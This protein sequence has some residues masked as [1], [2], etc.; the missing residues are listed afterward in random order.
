[1]RALFIAVIL[2]VGLP[3]FS[4]SQEVVVRPG[5]LLQ[6]AIDAAPAG[7]VIVLSEGRWEEN[8]KIEKSLTLRGTGADVTVISGVE[9]GCPVVWIAG[10]DG[11]EPISV[12]IE[13]L[14]ITGAAGE[15]ANRDKGICAYGVL[16]QGTAYAE[17]AG[18][19]VSGNM[20]GIG[21]AG[22]ARA[23]ITGC[24]ISENWN[25]VSLS[26]SSQA[27]ITDCTISN[28]GGGIDLRDSARAEITDNL[29]QDNL[30]AGIL[31]VSDGQVTGINNT[32]R[33]NG[34]DLWGNLPSGLR[35]PL[36]EATQQEIQL[37]DPAYPT[38][39]HAVDAL[40]PGGRL[41]LGDGSYAGGIT[42]DKD[43]LIKMEEGTEPQ[44]EGGPAV[45]SL[46][47]TARV[48]LSGLLLT[49]GRYGLVGGATVQTEVTSCTISENETG[50][51]LWGSTQAVIT[52]STILGN[53]GVGIGLHRSS[54]A[55][56][57]GCTISGN[58]G[59]GIG[60]ADLAWA[61]I[62]D[63]TISQNLGGIGLWDSAQAGISGCTI[64]E[65]QTGIDLWESAQ[66]EISG[67]TISGGWDGIRLFKSARATIEGNEIVNNEGYGVMLYQWPCYDTDEAFTGHVAGGGNNIPGPD[68]PDGNKVGAVC[69]SPELDFLMT[70]E[71]GS[72]SP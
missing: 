44:I 67:C 57:V 11:G 38:L 27:T 51:F 60:L 49:S 21:L 63:S 43:L 32:M 2:A 45:I 54:L 26:G 71:G 34:V 65:N 42:I 72:W 15:C 7:A 62:I 10:P 40:L 58:S 37:P 28:G 48:R 16:V 56:I 68:A 39:Q 23:Y 17:I 12:V 13:G 30:E 18:C 25:G 1:M 22:S 24:T 59:V 3:I 64:S 46:V 41:I 35:V 52:S 8:V 9:E 50:I 29:I 55:K 69:P 47:G 61:G 31:S 19:T 70:E 66:A 20:H 33:D 36:M 14:S 4:F 5:E 6:T 53:K